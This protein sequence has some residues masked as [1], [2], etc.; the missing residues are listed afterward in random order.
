MVFKLGTRRWDEEPLTYRQWKNE[1][2]VLKAAREEL[3][4]L[5]YRPAV[6]W[7]IVMGDLCGTT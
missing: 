6:V 7:L 2:A 5:K 4:S 3:K 1:A